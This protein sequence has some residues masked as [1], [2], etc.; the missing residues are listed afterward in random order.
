MEDEENNKI[1]LKPTKKTVTINYK[2]YQIFLQLLETY[3]TQ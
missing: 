2:F 1:F 3:I